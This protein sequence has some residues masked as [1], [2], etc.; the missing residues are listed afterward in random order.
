MNRNVV[1]TGGSTG[2]GRATV[3]AF[4]AEGDRVVF[5]ARGE[6]RGRALL[7][8]HRQE[9]EQ[10]RLFFL[11]NDTGVVE[12]A[13]RL[14]AF[15]N[16][17]LGGCDILVNNAAI[18]IGGLL[19]QNSAE[20]YEKLFNVN[21][22]G[23]FLI[24]KA[25]LPMMREKKKGNI[26]MIASLA[27]MRGGYCMTLYCAT[28]AAVINMAQSMALDYMQYGI[29]V[30]IISPSATETDMF[31][32]G[33]GQETIDAFNN[34]NPAHIMGK[35]EDIANAIV[36]VTDDKNAYM[37]GQKIAVDGGLSAWNGEYSQSRMPD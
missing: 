21:V 28:K 4:L 17:K 20:D 30:N 27:G 6:Q 12:D 3:E 5:T 37:N 7:E 8:K 11:R 13:E 24:S 2:I 25:F 18:F 22:R 29:R 34:L 1:V 32:S 23:V 9:T 16:E 19:H 10:G 35:P 14:A 36:C 26:I 15:T 33:N 31:M